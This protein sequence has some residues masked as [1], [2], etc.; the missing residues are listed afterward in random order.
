MNGRAYSFVRAGAVSMCT[1]LIRGLGIGFVLPT[2]R[3]VQSE[4]ILK[5]VCY[6]LRVYVP[7][8]V[9]LG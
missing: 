5:L 6:I 4:L 2:G 9:R 8:G 1:V 3:G 7:Y